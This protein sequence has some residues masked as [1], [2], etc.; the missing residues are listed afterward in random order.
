M[1]TA[2]KGK[3]VD[4]AAFADM[5]EAALDGIKQRGKAEAGEKTMIDV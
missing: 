5:V 2:C 3:Q 4:R 1:S